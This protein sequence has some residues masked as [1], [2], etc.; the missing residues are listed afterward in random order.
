M[1]FDR[2]LI[3]PFN[4]G[5]QLDLRP[6]LVPED[7]FT[8]LRNAYVFRG[9]VV[10]RFGSTLMGTGA[11]SVVTQQLLSRLR[12]LVNTTNPG[13][14]ASGNVPGDK[15]KIGQLF[16]IGDEIFT[17]YQTGTPAVMLTTGSSTTHTYDTTTGAYNFV[18]AAPLTDVYFYPALPVM[19]ITIFGQGPIN[20]QPSY[21]FDTRFA[22]VFT[23]NSWQRSG[24]G[25]TPEWH[26][27]DLN[28]FW[29]AN[30]QGTQAGIPVLFVTNFQVSNLNGVGT[31]TDDPI[32]TFNSLAPV[33]PN[34]W[35]K[36]KQYLAPTGAPNTGPFLVT[37]RIVIP[38]K[39]RLLFL[40]TVENDN[41]GGL[42]INENYPQRCRFTHNG[43][44]FS[45]NALYQ[46]DTTDGTNVADGGN[47]ID[48]A[49]SE[50][51]I[52]AEFIKDRLIVFFERSTW[53]LAYTGNEV[54]PFVWQKINTELGSESQQSS[55]PFDKIILTV[56]NTG[57]H[58]CSGP[59]VERID[60]KIPDEVFEIKDKNIG[61]QRVAGIRDY[62]TE[63]VYWTIPS[64]QDPLATYPNQVLVYN[65]RTGSWALNDDCITAFGY[66]EQNTDL[67]WANT[68]PLTWEE[69]NFAWNSFIT[70]AQF[71]QI[72]AGNPEGYVFIIDPNVSKNAG[73]LQITNM[74]V[75]NN[76]VTI[77]IIDHTLKTNDYIDI[78]NAQ[79]ITLTPIAPAPP[80][81]IFQ[82]TYV[83]SNTVTIK[84]VMIGTYTGGGTAARVSNINIRSKQWNPYVSNEKNVYLARI[85]FCV[86]KTSSGQI[87]VDYF[88][89]ASNVSMI[90]E[91]T[92][93]NTIMGT[94][95]LETSPYSLYPLEKQQERLWHPIYFQT[96]GEFVQI[97]LSFNNAQITNASIAYADFELEGMILYTKAVGRLQ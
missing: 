36:Y 45:A 90:T 10:K 88:P 33:T 83:D 8:E 56:G 81:S 68:S 78:Q 22:Y 21:A 82:V 49:T 50:Q 35:V 14:N 23:G 61:V 79:G 96:D 28:F 20:N 66:F 5:L 94:N 70:Q 41:S 6:W 87:T 65:Y 17:V 26:G 91:G 71:R 18:G 19:G 80:S 37:S 9:R 32:W 34:T 24:S 89:S 59:N 16:S 42:G 69:M 29:T 31:A 3:A 93:T 77:T 76:I 52:S 54:L 47:F 95:V 67:T 48:A 92:L 51:I 2:F 1:P 43:S 39:D 55:V 11:T 30:W 62:E 58:A 73:V 97:Q 15:Y 85:D 38:F 75:S 74:T 72:I 13:G 63:L 86:L 46:P 27:N 53:E 57:I 40:N 60:N 4:T 64:T 25:T 7:A 84:A 12:I 44:P